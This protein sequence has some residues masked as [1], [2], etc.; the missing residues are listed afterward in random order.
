MYIESETPGLSNINVRQTI[1]P[2]HFHHRLSRLNSDLHPRINRNQERGF[3]Q[4]TIYR[5]FFV[6]QATV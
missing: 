4:E 2:L 6:D 5:L 1:D 3:Q